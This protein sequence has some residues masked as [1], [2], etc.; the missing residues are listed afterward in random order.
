MKRLTQISLV[1]L[2]LFLNVFF[3]WFNSLQQMEYVE[4]YQINTHIQERSLLIATQG[5]DYKNALVDQIIQHYEQTK[6]FIKVT[7]VSSLRSAN[8]DDW[9]AIVIIQVWEKWAPQTAVE[10]FV[11]EHYDPQK[12]FIVTTSDSEDSQMDNIDGISGASSIE[13]VGE[14]KDII[15]KWL[16]SSKLN[17]NL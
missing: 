9:D 5:S 15:L 17:E 11:R 1:L 8:P 10:N 12:M 16:E 7:D 13:R 14:D 6:T 3:I 4:E 2:S